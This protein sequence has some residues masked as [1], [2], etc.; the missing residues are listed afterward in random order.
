MRP[1][2]ASR[3]AL[4]PLL[5]AAGIGGVGCST[6]GPSEPSAPSEQTA[7][8][9][10]GGSTT[11]KYP[12]V[13]GMISVDGPGGICT[14]TLIAPNLALTARHCVSD[15][16]TEYIDCQST[17]FTTDSPA[18]RLGVTVENQISQNADFIGVRKVLLPTDKTMCGN[19]IALLILAESIPESDA[20]P[21]I[22]KIHEKI[23]EG[24][25]IRQITAIGYGI[26]DPNDQNGQ[27]AGT[28]RIREKINVICTYDAASA[29]RNCSGIDQEQQDVLL[30]EADLVVDEG[31][32]Q[33]D[34]GSSA[35]EQS[36]FDD[37]EYYSVGVLSR[38]A[39]GTCE[40]GVYTRVDAFKDFIID[41]AKEAAEIG[42]YD[43]PSWVNGPS[44]SSSSGG[45]SSGGA[46]EDKS[47]LGAECAENSECASD[48]CAEIGDTKRC[49]STCEGSCDE[50][51]F[52]CNGDGYCVA[53]ESSSSS[54][55]GE[56]KSAGTCK[57]EGCNQCA[58][59]TDPTKPIPWRNGSG[60]AVLALGVGLF[61]R[62]RSKR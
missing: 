12:F 54:S 56:A 22:P 25:D 55:G 20:K 8:A 24:A 46:S 36:A 27:T 48:L 60:A 4:L 21:A 42:G 19:D 26:S 28:R 14:A 52:E 38:G 43:A 39:A 33:G 23:N 32:C 61:L 59:A 29:G 57:E 53:T 6:G 18:S 3:A 51:G 7:Q 16:N 13:L 35:F 45:S 37:D 34:S 2:I 10:Y 62:R 49:T 15:T 58:I 50:E 41:G 31:T 5:L 40:L 1:S 17:R 44:G 30:S 11:T 9:I 47:S